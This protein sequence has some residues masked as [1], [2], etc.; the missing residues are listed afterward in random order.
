[1][2]AYNVISQIGSKL[3]NF[4]VLFKLCSH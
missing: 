2:L 1:M 3:Y 4:F